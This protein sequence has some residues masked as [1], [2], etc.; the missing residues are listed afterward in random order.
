MRR[1]VE[2]IQTPE[3][4]ALWVEIPDDADEPIHQVQLPFAPEQWCSCCIR[5]GEYYLG[6]RSD[7]LSQAQTIL[8]QAFLADG[9]LHAEELQAL[10]LLL[11]EIPE[12]AQ[13]SPFT[14][15]LA[16]ERT[17]RD[18]LVERRSFFLSQGDVHATLIGLINSEWAIRAAVPVDDSP[19][20]KE[21][22]SY[23]AALVLPLLREYVSALE[24]GFTE[25]F[26]CWGVLDNLTA[27][28]CIGPGGPALYRH[29]DAA[30][31]FA[32]V[33]PQYS[34]Y[35]VT[36]CPERGI[37]LRKTAILETPPV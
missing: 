37:V 3:S 36:V 2:N 34:V 25:A 12:H 35:P 26:A 19:A 27:N 31:R 33:S 22:Q 17:L 7:A 24:D 14:I 20:A 8:L 15:V 11:R 1:A 18:R 6:D 28:I 10:C 23:A 9:W 21:A 16:I 5:S 29:R 4:L 30:A 32:E 13:D